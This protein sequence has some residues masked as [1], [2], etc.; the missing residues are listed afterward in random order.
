LRRAYIDG[1]LYKAQDGRLVSLERVRTDDEVQLVSR[2]LSSGQQSSILEAMTQR[3]AQF[4][5]QIEANELGVVG[6]VPE[7]AEVLGR[8]ARWLEK[9]RS[10]AVAAQPNSR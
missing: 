4:L 6:R 5:R 9:H 8:V 10:I 1:L 3:L 7:E 2:Q